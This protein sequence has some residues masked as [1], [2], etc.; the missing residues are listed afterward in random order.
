MA[1]GKSPRV[2]DLGDIPMVVITH[3]IPI[4]LAG[5]S[6]QAN[7]GFEQVNLE[8]QARL[9]SISTNARQVFAQQSNHDEIPVKQAN[10]AVQAIQDVLTQA[11]AGQ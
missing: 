1:L 7:A 6:D 5:Q 11:T 8:M 9:L 4:T 10:L 2:T 3:G